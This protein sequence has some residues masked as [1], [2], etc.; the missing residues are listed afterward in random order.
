MNFRHDTYTGGEHYW[1]EYK[2]GTH[3]VRRETPD[4]YDDNETVFTGHYEQCVEWIENTRIENADYDL[5]L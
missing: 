2:D 4:C 1:I 3:V 5:N